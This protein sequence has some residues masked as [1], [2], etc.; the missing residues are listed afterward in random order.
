MAE[1]AKNLPRV[2]T[3]RELSAY[4]RVNPST[5]YKL[6]WKGELPAFRVGADWRFHLDAID[7]WCMEHKSTRRRREPG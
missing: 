2:V 6:L 3:V 1:A 4:L 5:I 7:R